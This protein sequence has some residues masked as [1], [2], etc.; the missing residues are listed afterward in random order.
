MP[1]HFGLRWALATFKN[2][3]IDNLRLSGSVHGILAKWR[4]DNFRPSAAYFFNKL[5]SPALYL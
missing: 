5:F 2:V 1:F 3:G 4:H